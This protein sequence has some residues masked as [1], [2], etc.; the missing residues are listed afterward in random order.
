MFILCPNGAD[1]TDK[2][3]GSPWW[4][5]FARALPGVLRHRHLELVDLD[6]VSSSAPRRR[7]NAVGQSGPPPPPAWEQAPER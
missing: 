6:H 7:N 1:C 3:I 4:R 2:T 5:R